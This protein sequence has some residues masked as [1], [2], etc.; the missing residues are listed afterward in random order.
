MRVVHI[1]RQKHSITEQD[2]EQR[3][4]DGVLLTIQKMIG[5]YSTV[6]LRFIE[7]TL[8]GAFLVVDAFPE[9]R[10]K[11]LSPWIFEGPEGPVLIRSNAVVCCADDAKEIL[12]G[13]SVLVDDVK[14]YV[15]FDPVPIASMMSMTCHKYNLNDEWCV[16]INVKC[17]KCGTLIVGSTENVLDRNRYQ[18]HEV[19]ITVSFDEV[20]LRCELETCCAIYRVA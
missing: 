18:P 16:T 5:G 4:P 20:V 6:R 14:P 19:G 17:Q 7:T 3:T 8:D 9:L 15:N 12:H 11:R 13:T 10:N 2:I 1:D